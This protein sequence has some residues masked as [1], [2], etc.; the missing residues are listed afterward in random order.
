MPLGH[1]RSEV[2]EPHDNKQRL[3]LRP[4]RFPDRAATGEADSEDTKHIAQDKGDEQDIATAQAAIYTDDGYNNQAKA[5]SLEQQIWRRRSAPGA[6][7]G[8]K[9]QGL[10]NLHSAASSA[11][12]GVATLCRKRR[13]PQA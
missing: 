13:P 9:K 1:Y 8:A 3:W 5:R 2:G 12:S 4:R 11:S 10:L 6:T 7:E